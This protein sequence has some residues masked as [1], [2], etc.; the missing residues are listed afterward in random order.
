[1]IESSDRSIVAAQS[2][3]RGERRKHRQTGKDKTSNDVEEEKGNCLKYHSSC[4][5]A[6]SCG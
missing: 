2:R 5:K 3:K 4:V 6:I 1:M